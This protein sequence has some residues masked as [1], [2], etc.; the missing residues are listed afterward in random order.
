MSFS[1][2]SLRIGAACLA[3]FL[4]T[5]PAVSDCLNEDQPC[6]IELGEYYIKRPAGVK[7]TLPA[8]MFLH[9]Y[10]SNGAETM[11]NAGM[12]DAVLARGYVMI[13]P[14]G[15]DEL[16]NNGTDWSFHPDFHEA[17]DE[18]TFLRAVLD[19]AAAKYGIDRDRVLL[20]GFSIGGSMTAY[21]ACKDPTLARAYAPIAG[22]FW[23]PYRSASFCRGPVRLL[24]THG[25]TDTT[26]PL[27]GRY[28]G[29]SDGAANRVAQGDAFYSME[30]WRA[31]NGCK[32][33]AAD[34]FQM[35]TMFWH[36]RWERC[37][38]GSALE[39]VMWQGS[40]SI[41][42]GWADMAL[43]WFERP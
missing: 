17:R 9:G 18:T 1:G 39:F 32:E 40:H 4:G 38:P 34:A 24:H 7:G 21:A 13:A 35:D 30:V 5:V 28:L 37:T 43:T 22:N 20:A 27:E 23:R 26:I 10:G 14:S 19:D 42:K 25:W 12:V 33:M 3:V 8:L 41:P 29:P 36:R 6:Q 31:V 16:G 15:R 2:V 11:R